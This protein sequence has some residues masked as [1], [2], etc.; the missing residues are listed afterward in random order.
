MSEMMKSF[1]MHA[2]GKVGMFD[3]SIPRPGPIDAII[4][5][6]A[7]MCHLAR[8]LNRLCHEWKPQTAF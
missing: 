3:K 8:P 5:T 7:H 1:V 6:T 2:I 4:R